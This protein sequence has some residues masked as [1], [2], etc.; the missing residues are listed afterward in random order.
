VR[1]RL[2]GS[3]SALLNDMVFMSALVGVSVKELLC[4]SVMPYGTM[5]CTHS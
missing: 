2:R 1:Q 3:C 4:R 5:S